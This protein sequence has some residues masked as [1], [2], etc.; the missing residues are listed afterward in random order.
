MNGMGPMTMVRGLD[1]T[2]EQQKQVKQITRDLRKKHWAM[3]EQRMTLAEQLDD[4]YSASEKPDP[5]KISELY[6]KYF[7]IRKQMIQDS[8][9]ARNKI[10]D[11][12]TAEQR[13]QLKSQKTLRRQHKMMH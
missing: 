5:A 2:E 11:L 8:L 3:M 6:G 13:E 9:E 4:A 7:E 10:Y 12:L 1:L